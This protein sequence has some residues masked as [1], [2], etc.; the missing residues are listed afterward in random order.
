M[1]QEI[2]LNIVILEYIVHIY[3]ILPQIH[4]TIHT[5]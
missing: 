3:H 5:A 1:P 4:K 2:T